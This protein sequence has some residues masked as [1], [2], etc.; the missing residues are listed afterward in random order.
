M[1]VVIG[2]ILETRAFLDILPYK[3][4]GVIDGP[5]LSWGIRVS[6]VYSRI[7]GFRNAGMMSELDTVVGGY[8]Q[9]IPPELEQ[10]V[11]ERF[12]NRFRPPTLRKPPHEHVVRA[13]FSKCQYM[14]LLA[15]PLSGP[16]SNPR[17]CVHLPQR[18]AHGY[19]PLSSGPP[20]CTSGISSHAGSAAWAPCS[21][22]HVVTGNQEY[23]K[24]GNE[25]TSKMATIVHFS[26]KSAPLLYPRIHIYV[27]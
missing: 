18:D 25:N 11:N 13:P 22:P 7:Q 15:F 21:L 17:T 1:Y 16:S 19:W 14:S 27:H 9:Y 23:I 10:H 5:F 20:S 4:V 12:R 24:I 2:T 8:S 6:E 26:I 3:F